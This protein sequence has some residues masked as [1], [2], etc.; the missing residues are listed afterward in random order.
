MSDQHEVLP[1]LLKRARSRRR[2]SQ[3][4]LAL[5]LGISQRHLSFVELGRARP[6]RDLLLRWLSALEVPL[7]LRNQALQ[8]AGHAPAFDEGGWDA[9]GLEEAR[10]AVA[11]L[12][13]SHEPWPALL[14]GPEWDVVAANAGVAWL[15][16][17]VG[18]EAD[19][20]GPDGADGPPRVNLLDL[21]LG[22]LGAVVTNLPEAAAVL[23]GQL[24]HEAV[25]RPALRERVELVAA[26]AAQLDPGAAFPPVLVSRYASRHGEL[27]FLSM[28]TTFGTPHSVTLESLRVE[29]MFPADE[30]TRVLLE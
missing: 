14:L 9:A 28:F 30:A 19:L 18:V 16:D 3:L 29:L 23:L 26:V 13:R 24:R 4:D 6:S 2:I 20:P 10:Q 1:G 11:R 17:A 21:A 25:T 22:P 15:L 5:E 8:A 7:L 12:L 27:A